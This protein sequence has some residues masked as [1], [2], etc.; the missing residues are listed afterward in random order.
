MTTIP[1]GSYH[2][3]LP[4]RLNDPPRLCE[5]SGRY[6]Y[7]CGDPDPVRVDKLTGTFIRLVETGLPLTVRDAEREQVKE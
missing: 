2:Y 1:S 6:A 5:V 3:F 4:G 7:F